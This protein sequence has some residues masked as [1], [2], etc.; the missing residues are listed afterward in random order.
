MTRS[1]SILRQND[2]KQTRSQ[3]IAAVKSGANITENSDDREY[4][5]RTKDA[6]REHMKQSLE[7]AQCRVMVTVL[8]E[9]SSE[10]GDGGSSGVAGVIMVKRERP[11]KKPSVRRTDSNSAP[12]RKRKMAQ[13]DIKQ[14]N[15]PVSHY[16]VVIS[17]LTP[18][19]L[20]LATTV[21]EGK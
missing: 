2:I 16:F 15:I 6:V 3:I 10:D 9:D 8:S 4:F 5:K 21:P 12:S 18:H 20:S 11:V 7:T 17:S 1:N 19:S 14:T 13:D